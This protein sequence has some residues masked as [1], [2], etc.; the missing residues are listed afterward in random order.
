VEEDAMSPSLRLALRTGL[1]AVAVMCLAGGEP[2]ASAQSRAR[3][4][5]SPP[6]APPAVSIG[7]L[8]IVAPGMGEEGTEIRAF[9]ESPGTSLTL[10][11][12][13]A[14]GTGIVEIDEDKSAINSIK[15]D[16]GANLLEEGRFG[17]F[18]KITK[19]G[20]TGMI[21]VETR[22]RPSAGA[23]SLT[24]EGSIA[25]TS[26]TGTKV[27]KVSNLKLESGRT[28]KVGAATVTVGEVTTE[29]EYGSLTL[30]LPRSVFMTI[31]EF[32]FKEPKGAAVQADRMGSG[33]MGEDAEVSFRIP[34]AL[35]AANLELDVWQN[36]KEQTVP[37]SLK[38]GL[39]L[40]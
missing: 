8:R 27:Q 13:V 17:P 15:D 30:K 3:G 31:K 6:A 25:L 18:P 10:F 11:V 38:L 12:K 16:T 21:E 7:G 14:D 24:T 36:L 9:N 34:A 40:R 22:G 29:G 33:W 26:S 2:G 39:G 5:A 37:F 19:D 32:R 23:T 4:K 28:F 20:S 35:K 1:V